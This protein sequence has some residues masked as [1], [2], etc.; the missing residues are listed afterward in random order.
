VGLERTITESLTLKP[1]SGRLGNGAKSTLMT[2]TVQG[3][4]ANCR[5]AA[6]AYLALILLRRVVPERFK[7]FCC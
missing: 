2:Q 1:G 7:D 3:R 4:G 6:N 5:A